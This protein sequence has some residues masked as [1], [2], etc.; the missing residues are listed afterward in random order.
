[1]E[2]LFLQVFVSLLLVASSIVLFAFSARLRDH[3]HADRMALFPLEDDAP[4]RPP[5]PGKPGPAP[6]P[7]P[8]RKEPRP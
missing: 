4:V 1:M 2:V 5:E 6:D 3:E 7:N 8:P